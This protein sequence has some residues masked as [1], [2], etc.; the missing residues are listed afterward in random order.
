MTLTVVRVKSCY[1]ACS[2]HDFS[3]QTTSI[4]SPH[5]RGRGATRTKSRRAHTSNNIIQEFFR[6]LQRYIYI[7]KFSWI[8]Q[9]SS[10]FHHIS[11]NFSTKIAVLV[12]C[13]HCFQNEKTKKTC[14]Y[15]TYLNNAQKAANL[16][17]YE[18]PAIS[19]CTS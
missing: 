18:N 11:M 9:N 2:K 15:A 4:R 19:F 17:Q 7:R 3:R 13:T 8:S 12:K 6:S 5:A 10:T 1:V 16:Q 14:N